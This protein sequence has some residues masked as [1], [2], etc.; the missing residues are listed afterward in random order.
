MNEV[1]MLTLMGHIREEYLAEAEPDFL[2]ALIPDRDSAATAA[3]RRLPRRLLAA[4]ASV[5]LT[6]GVGFGTLTALTRSGVIPMDSLPFLDRF[7]AL[8]A[9]LWPDETQNEEETEREPASEPP[10]ES[11]TLP[12]AETQAQPGMQ[13]TE[14]ESAPGPSCADGHTPRVLLDRAATCYA[15][16][17][18]RTVCEV[19]GYEENVYGEERLHH[20]FSDG[21][22]TVC[23]LT[24]GAFESVI[25]EYMTEV[26]GV[27]MGKV[28][29]VNPPEGWEVGG[30]ILFPNVC[31]TEEYG[32]IPACYVSESIGFRFKPSRVVV[33]EGYINVY[34]LG[35]ENLEE[36]V[37]PSTLRSI[38]WGCFEDCTA[39]RSVTLP[40]GLTTIVQYAFKGC[41]ALTDLRI[42][43]SVTE[44]GA[45]AFEGCTN[46]TLDALPASLTVLGEAAFKECASITVS[47]IPA[48]VTEIP[49]DTF[50]QCTSIPSMTIPDTVISISDAAFYGCSSMVSIRLSANLSELSASILANCSSLTELE[51]PP[52]VLHIRDFALARTGLTDIRIPASV[53]D[54]GMWVFQHSPALHRV[55]FEGAD[56]VIG[57]RCFLDCPSLET[58]ELPLHMTAISGN[59]FEKCTG[60]REIRI[61]NDVRKIDGQ[62]FLDC[63]ALETVQFPTALRELHRQAFENCTSLKK[64]TMNGTGEAYLVRDNGLIHLSTKTLTFAT[65]E[66]LIPA[67]GSVTA[68]GQ[69]AF[70]GQ[71]VCELTIPEGVTLINREAFGDCRRLTEIHLPSTLTTVGKWMFLGCNAL[72]RVYYNGTSSQW[73]KLVLSTDVDKDTLRYDVV[74]TDGVLHPDYTVTPLGQ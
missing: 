13:E 19:C 45:F 16:S 72:E 20:T 26:D 62:A 64:L 22:C 53:L 35:N 48:G 44:I 61:P 71:P 6:L 21:F 67:D 31:F 14:E 51:I 33:P 18:L 59:L 5:L 50:R 73:Q 56:T 7:P 74:C 4:A 30:E 24:E 41:T 2:K 38:N 58:V 47:A 29:I 68:I 46:L 36:V 15:V 9:I 37:L 42:P 23:G 66:A 25:A 63:T 70:Y 60:L 52:S 12:D 69:Y 27:V 32:L 65:A 17:R 1:R 54:L 57:N 11:D 3:K 34:A 43:D 8:Q 39:L 40:E 49:R 55:V 28:N 10:P